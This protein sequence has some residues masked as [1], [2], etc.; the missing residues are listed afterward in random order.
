MDPFR[1]PMPKSATA[2]ASPPIPQLAQPLPAELGGGEYR[3][4]RGRHL[5][6][7]AMVWWFARN[8]WSHPIFADLA[9]FALNEKGAVHTSQLSHIRNQKMR[10]IGIKILD[11][12]GAVN[13]AVWAYHTDRQLLRTLR[14]GPLTASIEEVLQRSEPLL[15][16][17]TNW[18]L[19]QGD[20][21][22]VYLGYLTLPG[23]SP[24]MPTAEVLR[25]I[26]QFV[27]PFFAD[28]IRQCGGDFFSFSEA[29]ALVFGG[30]D[31]CRKAVAVAAGLDTYKTHELQ[32]DLEPLA[33]LRGSLDN[34][35]C[36][37]AEL[38]QQISHY[39]L[40]AQYEAGTL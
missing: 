34:S 8:D 6:S 4:H 16:P 27:G 2:K 1:H 33:H 31:Q 38:V 28:A 25:D 13:L 26:A 39:A 10:M 21:M 12:F 19:D 9:A 35:A 40:S 20:W 24:M 11:A 15:S 3:R 23:I 22:M 36:T 29:A 17:I 30:K 5:V 7:S 18:P 32:R 14:C 37:P